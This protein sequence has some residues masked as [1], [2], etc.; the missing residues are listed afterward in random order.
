MGHEGQANGSEKLTSH[1]AAESS[2]DVW[3]AGATVA[4]VL[5]TAYLA[6]YT[7]KLFIA[8]STMA[9][10]AK[11]SAEET[12]RSMRGAERPWILKERISVRTLGR[13][14]AMSA[15]KIPGGPWGT[16]E[17]ANKGKGVAFIVE[18]GT[19]FWDVPSRLQIDEP[20]GVSGSKIQGT[21]P[22]VPGEAFSIPC[23]FSGD[24]SGLESDLIAGERMLIL[25][26]YIKYED[27]HGGMHETRFTYRIDL[28]FSADSGV[29]IG[30]R[31]HN[32][33]T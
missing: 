22:L 13:M 8:T 21:H 9:A 7:R 17:W 28:R 19:K 29:Y 31:E 24:P 4:L 26:A 16:V 30:G 12:V 14:G 11:T 2:A 3:V 20:W 33:A 15:L 32:D 10:D 23:M 5:V 25:Q 27:Q 18:H 1:N 6:H